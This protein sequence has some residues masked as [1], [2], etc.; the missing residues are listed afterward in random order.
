MFHILKVL[1]V[2][3]S[4]MTLTCEANAALLH[5]YTFDGGSVAVDSVGGANGTLFGGATVVNGALSLNGSDAYVQTVGNH[6]IPTSGDFTVIFFAKQTAFP[7]GDYVELISQGTSGSGFY[8]GYNPSQN[9]RITDANTTTIAF[10]TDGQYHNYAL[11]Y[12]S[13]TAAFY[14]DGVFQENFA[15]L[16]LGAGGTDTRFGRQFDPATE[17]FNGYI[18]NIQIYDTALSA[19]EIAKIAADGP[20]PG[21]VS[22]PTMTEWGMIIF[23]V[24]AGVGAVYYLRRQPRVHD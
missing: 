14:I 17:F 8:I 15:A 11:T 2:I 4:L 9:F 13:G 23:V 20:T 6:I 19:G 12:S 22:I 10:P 21:S 1:L 18:D 24:L 3:V 5:K 7:P 16:S